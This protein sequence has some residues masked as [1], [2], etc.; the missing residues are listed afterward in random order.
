M[1]P[2]IINLSNFRP[3]GSKVFAGRDRGE[4]VRKNS[5][6][7]SIIEGTAPVQIVIPDDVY[8]VNPSFLEEFLINAVT[9]LG[10]D[11]FFQKV[12]FVSNG[13]YKIQKD[14]EEAVDRISRT[15]TAL[16]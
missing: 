9:I 3:V 5:K 11:L 8:S 4:Q 16:A 15:T 6:I 12:S 10:K 13:P 2:V 7:D 14:L 1:N